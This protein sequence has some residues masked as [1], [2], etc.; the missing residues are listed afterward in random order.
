M[1]VFD[2]L[3]SSK[4]SSGDV[5]DRL[6]SKPS[7]FGHQGS[8]IGGQVGGAIETAKSN[9]EQLLKEL[10]VAATQAIEAPVIHTPQ[11]IAKLMQG[12][13]GKPSVP[14][15]RETFLS[16]LKPPQKTKIAS[17]LLADYVREGLPEEL[18]EG[19]QDIADLETLLLPFLK[20]LVPSP[21]KLAALGE[22]P[23]KPPSTPP[24]GEPVKILPKEPF[25][26]KVGNLLEKAVE[27]GKEIK[28]RFLP[29]GEPER[30]AS[31][32]SKP[33]AVEAKNRAQAIISKDRQRKVL[34]SLDEEAKG[35]IQEKIKEHVPL[36]EKIREGFDFEDYHNKE[37]GQLKQAADKF[38]PEIDPSPLSRFFSETR[39]KYRG[40]P[41]LHSDA[42][43]IV[44]EMA[45][46][47]RRLPEDLSTLLKIRKSNT[48]KLKNIYENRLLKGSRR[49]YVDF[50]NE[51]NRKIDE[52]IGKTLPEDSAWFKRYKEMNKEYAQYKNAQGTLDTLEPLL[53]EKLSATAL[54]KLAE[55]PK[56]QQR[57]AIKMGDAGAKQIVN[58]AKDLKKAR[59]AIKE[60][61]VQ[62]RSTFDA[63]YPITWLFK[64]AGI[65][66]TVQKG[67]KYARKGY[68][69]YL[70]KPETRKA[71]DS[72]LKAVAEKDLPAYKVA[73][74]DLKK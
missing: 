66:A 9:P 35:L 32:L 14:E 24:P 10:P 4:A 67:Y 27:K 41:E 40:I 21:E 46:F 20:K 68:G 25:R 47:S 51:Y 12:L 57:L 73:T 52:A 6:A 17:Q 74:E 13:L 43:T 29:E 5:F 37:F 55:Q 50:I 39:K 16:H 11:L 26:E 30:F 63:V 22:M 23:K 62:Q 72:A 71:F 2:R 53:R 64:P 56:A 48:Q 59:D 18:K 31:G 38:N 28:E 33:R 8:L 36:T 49:E 60:M 54:T 45:A 1:D 61:T 69:Y 15:E 3:S 7:L 70:S 58:I 19:A 65:A 42:K 44:R 34:S